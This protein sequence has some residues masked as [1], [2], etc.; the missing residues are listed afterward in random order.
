M[1]REDLEHVI[2]AAC[3]IT[4]DSEIV[5]IGSQAILAQFPSAPAE[6]LESAEADLFPRH[7]MERADDIDG[8]I[9]E[10]TLFH[11]THGY[12]AHGV[13]PE[14]VIAP[15]GWEDR[16]VR[17]NNANTNDISGLCMEVHD[18]F[19]SKLV[20]NRTKDRAYCRTLIRYSLVDIDVL[21]ERLKAMPVTTERRKTLGVELE[22]M[23][24]NR[25]EL[26]ASRTR[27][28]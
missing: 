24:R 12:Y 7:H 8:N 16:L 2:R 17:L 4:D 23:I 9:G 14:T 1:R 18:L 3:E 22:S 21:R 13:G 5:V 25:P 6:V 19:L 28:G 20:A 26:S 10:L 27:L 15:K 11:E